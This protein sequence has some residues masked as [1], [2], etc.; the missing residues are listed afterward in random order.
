M[1]A[2]SA[3]YR[4]ELV[5]ELHQ[6]LLQL[7]DDLLALQETES[8]QKS[9]ESEGSCSGPR[10]FR[11]PPASLFNTDALNKESRQQGDMNKS[12]GA[13]TRTRES[14]PARLLQDPDLPGW[15]SINPWMDESGSHDARI[16]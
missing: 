6:V 5:E 14:A 11:S 10:L 15:A 1:L 4:V 7:A 13:K 9:S 3:V 2:V 12:A 16:S 8:H